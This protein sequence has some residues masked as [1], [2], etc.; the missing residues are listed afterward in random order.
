[1]LPREQPRKQLTP[2]FRSSDVP[3]QVAVLMVVW[4]LTLLSPPAIVCAAAAHSL[5]VTG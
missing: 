2:R 3:L 5:Y 1:M 4:L